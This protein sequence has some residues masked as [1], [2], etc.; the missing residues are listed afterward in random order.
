MPNSFSEIPIPVI[1]G[2][3]GSGKTA[4]AIELAKQLDAEI[5]SADSRQIY[6]ELDI[7]TAKPTAE[8]QRT[9]Q[10]HFID[11]LEVTEPYNAAQFANDTSTRIEAIFSSGKNVVVA[12]GSTLYLQGLLQGFSKLPESNPQIREKLYAALAEQGA[13][14]LY[15]KLKSL[16]PTH[17]ATL[18]PTK[19]QRLI[20][21]LEILE[22]STKTIS[23][24]KTEESQKP[25]FHF[26]PF[27][28]ALPRE[29]LYEK[30][31]LRTDEMIKK[32]FLEEA[33][34]LFEKYAKM[35]PH[36]VKINALAT[37]G[38]KELFSFLEGSLS[39]EEAKNLVKQHTRNYAKRQLTFFRNK[40]SAD[41]INFA[42]L[43]ENPRETARQIQ[44][45][46]RKLNSHY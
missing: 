24:L 11:E 33:T 34:L 31:N 9:V 41:W 38:Y 5:I 25:D 13:N 29:R 43:E 44:A 27:G 20:R 1:L 4:T 46:L 17:A 26:L 23:E 40:L 30:I 28:L 22:V 12:G 15:E 35:M 39:F 2:A 21:S 45:K 10:H 14:A 36:G 7:G 37:V 16:D 3:T 32:G 8:E 6:K 19:T 18:D 42:A